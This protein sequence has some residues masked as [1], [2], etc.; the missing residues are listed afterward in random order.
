MSLE[1]TFFLQED[2]TYMLVFTTLC[3]LNKNV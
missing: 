2:T 1:I 3:I